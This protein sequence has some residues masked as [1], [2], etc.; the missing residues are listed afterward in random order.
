MLSLNSQVSFTLDSTLSKIDSEDQIIDLWLTDFDNNGEEEILISYINLDDDNYLIEFWRLVSYA[1]DG[2][3]LSVYTKNCTPEKQFSRCGI[4]EFNNTKYL[5]EI[6]DEN[7]NDFRSCIIEIY[8]FDSQVL[9]DSETI[10]IG[11]TF[12]IFGYY[13]NT[14]YV[15]FLTFEN[16]NYI[17]LGLKQGD[18]GDESGQCGSG[19]YKFLFDQNSLNLVENIPEGG[20]K[21]LKYEE[22]DFLIAFGEGG[23]WSFPSSFIS[24]YSINKITETSPAVIEEIFSVS[25]NNYQYLTYL[26]RNDTNYSVCTFRNINYTGNPNFPLRVYYCNSSYNPATGGE[27]DNSPNCGYLYSLTPTELDTIYYSSRNS[28]YS[29][30]GGRI[31]T[32]TP[33]IPCFIRTVVFAFLGTAAVPEVREV[34]KN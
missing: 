23:Y 14:N 5:V 26:T 8:D 28:S 30:D 2:E 7:L 27:L 25:S 19:I 22:N 10:E 11:D 21:L 9:I 3:I 20:S 1:S 4:F 17:Y 31:A 15:K 18:E 16:S 24:S 29:G 13:F 6:Y 32:L 12:G 33:I 34:L